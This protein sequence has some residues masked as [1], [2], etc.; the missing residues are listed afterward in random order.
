MMQRRSMA[1]IAAR[2]AVA[3]GV[4]GSCVDPNAQTAPAQT[5]KAADDQPIVLDEVA[6]PA[7]ARSPAPVPPPAA[8]PAAVEPVAY[9]AERAT[10]GKTGNPYTDRF[11][12]L[13]NDIHN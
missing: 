5:P 13:W 4:F 8:A 7:A 1:A 12:A 9:R 10:V 6:P 11:V 2:A 3:V